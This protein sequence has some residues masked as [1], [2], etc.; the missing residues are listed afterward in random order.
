MKEVGFT[1]KSIGNF[2]KLLSTIKYE[3]THEGQDVAIWHERFDDDTAD[4]IFE[5]FLVESF[6]NGKVIDIEDID[7][8]IFCAERF[9]NRDPEAIKIRNK[10]I[11][12]NNTYWVE[13]IPDNIVIPCRFAE[14]GRIVREL[15]MDFFK[16]FAYEDISSDY[17]A[18][19]IKENI[20][21]RS[22]NTTVERL[23]KDAD[24]IAR[25]IIISHRCYEKGD[26]RYV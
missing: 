5:K 11:K 6:P 23:A 2:V 13:F 1:Y 20:R 12:I 7:T 17:I 16:D 8:I 9:L 18:R 15:C 4:G 19:F 10:Y 26:M 24:F 22:D 3:K 25:S 14:H 21:I